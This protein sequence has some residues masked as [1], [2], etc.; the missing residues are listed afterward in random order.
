MRQQQVRYLAGL[1]LRTTRTSAQVNVSLRV[2]TQKG[3]R[4]LHWQQGQLADIYQLRFSLADRNESI[5]FELDADGNMISREQYYP[6]GGTS[7]WTTDSQITSLYKTMRY[8]AKERDISGLLYYGYRYY[9]PWMMCWINTDPAGVVDGLNLFRMVRNNPL[10]FIDEDGKVPV[11]LDDMRRIV[12]ATMGWFNRARLPAEQGGSAE[13]AQAI[14]RTFL[15]AAGF[16]AGS[17]STYFRDQNA[18]ENEFFTFR[19]LA[20]NLL[21][22]VDPITDEKYR[23][24]NITV[25]GQADKD[26]PAMT[27]TMKG[28]ERKLIFNSHGN[29]SGKGEP[30]IN[31]KP[32]SAE[33][34]YN[35]MKV[36]HSHFDSSYDALVLTCCS[37]PEG[38]MSY[39]NELRNIMKKNIVIYSG[40]YE[41]RDYDSTGLLKEANKKLADGQFTFMV[42]KKVKQEELEGRVVYRKVYSDKNK[43]LFFGSNTRGSS[44]LH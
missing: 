40:I 3:V 27:Y 20:E 22:D 6:F 34:F 28:Q 35:C 2:I 8:S 32:L 42:N 4:I 24:N 44:R 14:L 41:F 17:I 39:G 10:T 36:Y 30:I 21:P 19:Q 38:A 33:E 16:L 25:I 43:F 26:L 9:A 11:N 15:P 18:T 31:G 1:E 29:I 23:L 7:V 12:R 37:T 13:R 5:Q